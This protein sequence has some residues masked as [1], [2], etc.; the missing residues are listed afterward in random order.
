MKKLIT[1]IITLSF[2]LNLNAFDAETNLSLENSEKKGKCEGCN[3][4]KGSKKGKFS[5]REGNFDREAIR[6]KMKDM[7]S[8]EREAFK[9]EMFFHC[10]VFFQKKHVF[11]KKT[12][13]N[14]KQKMFKKQNRE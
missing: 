1:A 5:Q 4:N 11:P 13:I 2:F 8:E 6:E 9:K 10:L 7:T 12:K 3:K 14:K